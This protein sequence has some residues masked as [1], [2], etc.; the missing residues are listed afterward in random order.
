MTTESTTKAQ[1]SDAEYQAAKQAGLLFTE[2]GTNKFDAAIHRFAR[3]I[4]QAVLQSPEVQGLR[5][6][7]A[8]MRGNAAVFASLVEFFANAADIDL[9]ETA[10]AIKAD[11]KE[12]ASRS[13][14]WIL[15]KHYA[16]MKEQ[17]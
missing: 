15:D 17:S 6:Q 12:V 4:E 16:A 9:E 5:E 2:Q 8:T 1:C 11:G 13:V 14:R 10:I 3:A 7:V